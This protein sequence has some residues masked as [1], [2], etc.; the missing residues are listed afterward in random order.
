[1]I[2]IKSE[3]SGNGHVPLQQYGT[4]LGCPV[5]TTEGI[6]DW[7]WR[8]VLPCSSTNY[9][10][11]FHPV[12]WIRLTIDYAA[13]VYHVNYTKYRNVTLTIVQLLCSWTLSIVS[14]LSK[15]LSCLYFKTQRFGDWI[16]S[17]SLG[18]TY[19]VGPSRYS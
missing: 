15:M 4:C 10:Y 14:S 5:W 13:K 12:V 7:V 6:V 17:P 16:L 19:S 11:C 2:I 1:M 18:K 9:F 8:S 3:Y